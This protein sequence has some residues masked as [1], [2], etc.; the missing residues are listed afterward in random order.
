[1]LAKAL[2]AL[3]LDEE[4]L[5]EKLGYLAILQVLV[6]GL[7]LALLAEH[8]RVLALRVRMCVEALY[9]N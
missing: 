6:L 3:L 1:M 2:H 9:E 8:E 7:Q 5:T 4:L